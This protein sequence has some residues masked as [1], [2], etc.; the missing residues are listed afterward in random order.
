MTD[1][2]ILRRDVRI[3][4][5][6]YYVW[7]RY[8]RVSTTTYRWNRYNVNTTT[9]YNW[10]RYNVT[11]KEQYVWAVY[12]CKV[13]EENT[14]IEENISSTLSVSDDGFVYKVSNP[15]DVSR[16]Y[17]VGTRTSPSNVINSWI[18]LTIQSTMIQYVSSVAKE[19]EYSYTLTMTKTR[20]IR[21][22]D[23]TGPGEF[24]Y[25]V[26]GDYIWSY[27]TGSSGD[28]KYWYESIGKQT[29]YEQGSANGTVTSTSFSAY[30]QDGVQGDYWYVYS[31]SRTEYSQGSANGTVT[32]TNRSQYPDNGRS[33]SYWYV[34][35]SSSV[36]YSQGSYI[37]Q[38]T[39]TN[40]NQYPDNNYSGNYWYVYQGTSTTVGNLVAHSLVG[41]V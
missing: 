2:I 16:G 22:T 35:S 13:Y 7:N 8:N 24:L 4:Q 26:Y 38:V 37:D 32:S 17:F 34:Y 20:T 29:V 10:N 1:C 39:S 14:Y 9:I 33:G 25:N 30:P 23:Q 36:S 40:R 27:P 21:T 11:S 5:T 18:C 12:T 28:G 6:T 3:N 31:S 15:E 41:G 19:T